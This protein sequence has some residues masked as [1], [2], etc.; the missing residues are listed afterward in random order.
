MKEEI[1]RR[2]ETDRRIERR[3]QGKGRGEAGRERK[4]LAV[5]ARRAA[6]S[7]GKSSA[8]AAP[9][10]QAQQGSSREGK[11]LRVYKRHML[12]APSR[13]MREQSAGQMRQR[14]RQWHQRQ[15]MSA[16]PS[17]RPCHVDHF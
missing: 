14:E 4:S 1:R 8:A 15:V 13:Y 6:C 2:T 7:A 3:G 16:R 9:T 17:P 12:T 11:I 5:Q 10:M